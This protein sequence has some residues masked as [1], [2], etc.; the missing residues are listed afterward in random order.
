MRTHTSAHPKAVSAYQVKVGT[1]VSAGFGL[2]NM[3]IMF[4]SFALSSIIGEFGLTTTEA[5]AI[6]TVTNLGML[7][8][9]ILFGILADKFGRV[10]MLS[11]SILIFGL[12]TGAIYFSHSV[13]SL[14]ILRFIA[15]IGGGGE[16][17]V[18][19]TIL[20][21]NFSKKKLGRT[22]SIVAVAGQVGAM[23]AAI[24]SMNI[25]PTYGW[26]FL[27]L[28]GLVPVV[29]TVFI[30]KH[31]KE[32]D[33]FKAIKTENKG[34]ISDLFKTRQLTHQTLV[35]MW[36]AIVQIAG[37]FGLMNWLPTIMQK[38]LN[39]TVA[40]SSS[41]MIATIIG[42]SLGM[43]T[44]GQI[45]DKLGPKVAFGLFL[46]ASSLAVYVLTIPTT[47]ASLTLVGAVVGYFSNG[48]FT[49]YGAVV[50]RLYPPE[51]RAT[52]NNVIMNTGRCIGGFSSIVIGFILAHYSI[53]TVMLFISV[54]YILSFLAMMTVKNLR[55]GVY[56]SL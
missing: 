46:I 32:S 51:V 38:K 11:L 45:L 16:Y 36:M 33:S 21:E 39:L 3:D 47:L 49:G 9:G 20:A 8:G 35:L 7:L 41:W 50:S 17:G 23:C 10:K 25:L 1:L 12:A 48:M 30:Q 28:F 52:A 18:G 29:L 56:W 40:G 2:E 6:S 37:Y 53:M 14:Y 44:F 42:M 22:S 5:G 54:L 34:K 4:L 24:L 27:F 15:G 19:M 31:L 55:A 26:R 43:L 13:T